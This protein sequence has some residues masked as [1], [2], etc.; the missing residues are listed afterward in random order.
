VEAVSHDLDRQILDKLQHLRTAS[1]VFAAG[2]V[3]NVI[4]PDEQIAFA[5][6]LEN[7]AEVIRARAHTAGGTVV[8]GAVVTETHD[9]A[10]G[11]ADDLR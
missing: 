10:G 9:Q 8:E 2:I 7:L 4:P 11:T 3:A 1:S 5:F 6:N